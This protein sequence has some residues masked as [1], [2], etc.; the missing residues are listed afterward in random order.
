MGL[1]PFAIFSGPVP[2]PS[3]FS[4]TWRVLAKFGI[5]SRKDEDT[6]GLRLELGRVSW[7]Y[8][9]EDELSQVDKLTVILDQFLSWGGS[10]RGLPPCHARDGDGMWPLGQGW[11]SP[12]CC[13]TWFQDSGLWFFQIHLVEICPKIL[14]YPLRRGSAVKLCPNLILCSSGP[15]TFWSRFFGKGSVFLHH[16]QQSLSPSSYLFPSQWHNFP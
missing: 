13:S 14:Y 16:L 3:R 10:C 8:P 1:Q 7:A 15:K 9:V 11:E 4:P 12:A 2:F 6:Q 5:W